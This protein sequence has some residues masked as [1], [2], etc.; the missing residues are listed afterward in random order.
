MM[1]LCRCRE[2]VPR[3]AWVGPPIVPSIYPVWYQCG[4]SQSKVIIGSDYVITRVKLGPELIIL[5]WLHFS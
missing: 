3:V 5:T 4:Q 2:G 1:V